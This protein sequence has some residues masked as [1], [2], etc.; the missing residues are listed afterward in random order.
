MSMADE[1]GRGRAANDRMTTA[2]VDVTQPVGAVRRGYDVNNVNV[3]TVSPTRP[4][5]RVRWSAVW[6]GVLASL[7]SLVILSLLGLAIGLSMVDAT[8]TATSGPPIVFGRDSAIWEG[9]MA[10]I[11]FLIGGYV[12]GRSANTTRRG[13]AALNGVVVFLLS[14]PFMLW[15]AG[16]GVG[17]VLGNLG[18]LIGGL[19]LF[20]QLHSIL[21]HTSVTPGD[22]IATRNAAWGALIGVL[23]GL[24]FSTI[25]GLLGARRRERPVNSANTTY[26]ID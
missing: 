24:L 11:S 10:I 8:T 9:A 25:G 16:Q 4:R 14:M 18:S 7:T 2:D 1:Q 6:A 26:S 3:E 17:V 19:G 5:D 13:T 21:T 15:L 12:A 20:G 23:L 22:V